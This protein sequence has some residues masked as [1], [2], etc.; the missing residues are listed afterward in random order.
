MDLRRA[1]IALLVGAA[2]ALAAGVARADDELPGARLSWVRAEGAD[3]CPAVDVVAAQVVQLLG[4]DPFRARASQE[5]EVLVERVDDRWRARL[6]LRAED[7]SLTGTREIVDEGS[8]CEALA[9]AVALAVALG[10]DPTTRPPPPPAAPP[11]PVAPRPTRPVRRPAG[12]SAPG[13]DV[14][15]GLY[16]QL[17][18]VPG[19]TFGV[20]LSAGL[21]SR[22]SFQLRV[23]GFFLPEVRTLR[24]GGA[25]AF[26]ATAFS[27]A[28]C[29]DVARGARASF[30]ACATVAAGAAHAVAVDLP[31][32][33][34]TQR[35]WIGAGASARLGVR[36]AGPLFVEARFDAIALPLRVRF[37]FQDVA[38]PAF[39]QSVIALGGFVGLGLSFR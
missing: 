13:A 2:A 25:V 30:A 5:V 7:H 6:Y 24:P 22:G 11:V 29:F 21:W 38:E 1:S 27:L 36:V 10:V 20:D 26:G 19:S 17:G 28:G 3:A 14:A 32:A 4:R 37:D 18:L 35:G 16:A 12:P 31:A 15:L 34:P 23:G 9:T 8:N 33:A 39:E